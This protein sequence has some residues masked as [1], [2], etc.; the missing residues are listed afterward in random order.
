MLKKGNK[1]N[2][3]ASVFK[4]INSSLNK[5]VKAGIINYNPIKGYQIVN[6]NVEKQS[7]TLNEIQ[8]IID[9]EI[10]LRHKAMIKSR[11]MFLFSFY[12]AGMRFTDI[13]KLQW[14]NIVENEIVYT[15]NKARNRTGGRRSIPLNPKSRAILE[16]YK[17]KMIV[18]FFHHY[19]VMKNYQQ[20]KLNTEY[21]FKITT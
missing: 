20:K 16:K 5:A 2:T 12:T 6:E 4:S 11:D 18:L 1:I 17:G 14:S 10:H 13:C 9:L 3:I 8:T 19:M 15:M 7:L 21:R